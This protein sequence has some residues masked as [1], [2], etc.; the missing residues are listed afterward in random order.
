[1]SNS[2]SPLFDV[3][4]VTCEAFVY[5]SVMNLLL[6]H[7]EVENDEDFD[8]V[9]LLAAPAI[10]RPPGSCDIFLSLTLKVHYIP[11]T[12]VLPEY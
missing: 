1:M 11:L 9:M 10:S 6:I 12:T 3:R 2:T 8:L 5:R 4:A 7:G